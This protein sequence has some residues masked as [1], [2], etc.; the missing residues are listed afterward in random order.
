VLVHVGGGGVLGPDGG[1]QHQPDLVLL[2]QVAG[3]VPD[4]GFR[5][6]VADQLKAEGAAV[7][8]TGLLGVADV[9]LDVVG[10]VDGE[11]VGERGRGGQRIGRHGAP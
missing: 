4:P 10:A 9:E 11:G 2:K 5:A 7:E 8:V 6:A 3:R 1:G